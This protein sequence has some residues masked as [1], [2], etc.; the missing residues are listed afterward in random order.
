[1][2]R[3]SSGSREN[4]RS[5]AYATF[6][7][8][9]KTA[10]SGASQNVCRKQVE[11]YAWGPIGASG[12]CHLQPYR[13]IDSVKYAEKY[14]LLEHTASVLYQK[15]IRRSTRFWK[16]RRGRIQISWSPNRRC[17][18]GSSSLLR[19]GL[20]V[21]GSLIAFIRCRR[22]GRLANTPSDSMRSRPHGSRPARCWY[23]L[24]PPSW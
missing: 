17:T 13:G 20:I 7:R 10:S 6:L 15:R 22:L 1:M 3:S 14:R 8:C 5:L 19:A 11:Q 24:P 23:L 9:P 4:H 2:N 21:V 16:P 18:I 12:I